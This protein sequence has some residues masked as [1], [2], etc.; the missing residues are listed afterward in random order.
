ILPP[1]IT[2]PRPDDT[3]NYQ[4]RFGF[5]YKLT[6]RTVLRGGYGRHYGARIPGPAAQMN[7]LANTAVVD[8]PNDGRPDFPS[9]PFNGPWPTKAQLEG[10]FCLTP[11]NTTGL[12]P[13]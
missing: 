11:S 12:P 10:R 13:R 9:N 6:D 2:E 4:P 5:A 7:A 1:I 3:N 8:I